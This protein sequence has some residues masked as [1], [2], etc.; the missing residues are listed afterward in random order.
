MT[1]LVEWTKHI[2]KPTVWSVT[3]YRTKLLKDATTKV[4]SMIVTTLGKVRVNIRPTTFDAVIRMPVKYSPVNDNVEAVNR[5]DVPLVNIIVVPKLLINGNIYSTPDDFAKRASE[6][7]STS[8][9]GAMFHKLSVVYSYGSDREYNENELDQLA[10]D[11]S[12]VVNEIIK[13]FVDHKSK[14]DSLIK[15]IEILANKFRASSRVYPY[16]HKFGSDMAVLR[17][18]IEIDKPRSYSSGSAGVYSGL[19]ADIVFCDGD[20]FHIQLPSGHG[21]DVRVEGRKE[22][23]DKLQ[24]ILGEPYTGAR[25]TLED[26]IL[27]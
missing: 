14:Y 11:A 13:T 20:I 9:N 10:G 5:Y 3:D 2:H 15:E 21:A 7:D 25:P 1:S 23:I 12:K 27:L 19:A 16:V 6:L 8:I 24:S 22:L 18:P 4:A 26:A 17:M